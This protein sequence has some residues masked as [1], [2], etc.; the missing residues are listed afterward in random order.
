MII[1]II[2][3][4]DEE[5]K[6]LEE[7]MEKEEETTIAGCR[8]VKGKLFNRTVVLLK[9]GIG[10][11]NAAMATTILHERYQPTYIINTGS[12]GG[13]ANELEVGDLVIST[14][15]THH[16]VDV[17]AFDYAYGQVPGMPAMYEASQNLVQ[18]AIQSVDEMEH[19]HAAVGVIATGDSFMQ[20]EKKVSFVREKFPDMLAAEMEAAA[21]AQVCYQYRTPFVITRALSDIAGKESS[22]SFDA[23]LEKASNN[24]ADL[25]MNI[26]QKLDL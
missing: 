15:V 21:I 7:Y 17:T 8:F 13:F 18:L 3:A 6:Q 11:V 16:D 20:D 10:K 12:A 5:V 25:I 14:K 1:G 23:F 24:S 22:V 9:S 2:G 4:M 26:V 19:L